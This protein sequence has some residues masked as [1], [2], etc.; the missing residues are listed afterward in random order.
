MRKK[1]FKMK[2]YLAKNSKD[3]EEFEI[4]ALLKAKVLMLILKKKMKSPHTSLEAKH[5]PVMID[6]VLEIC[7]P[8]NGGFLWTVL[9][10]QVVI[11]RQ[12]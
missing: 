10:V 12:F 3:E 9:L 5:L 4:T 8:K 2:D 6:E 1:V 7:D 11:Q